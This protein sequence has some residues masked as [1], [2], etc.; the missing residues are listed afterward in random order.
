[1]ETNNIEELLNEEIAAQIRALYYL[2]AGSKEKTT[3]IND[4]TQLYKLRIEE[5]KSLMDADEKYQRRVMDE[6][7]KA[8]EEDFKRIQ[9][10]EQKKDR[11]IRIGITGAEILVPLLFY[12]VWM[13]NGFEFEKTG[14]VSS[15]T[16]R[17]LVSKFKPTKR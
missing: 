15:F 13:K 7:S 10:E 6:E 1:M 8:R 3:A 4:L 14:A 9:I 16:F 12:N 17:N 2:E 11:W 5:N